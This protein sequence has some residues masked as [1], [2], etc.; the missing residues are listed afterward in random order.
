MSEESISHWVR[1]LREEGDEIAAQKL[2]DRYFDRLVLYARKRFGTARRRAFDEEDAALSAFH[3]LCR[4]AV[5]GRFER[6][7]DRNDLWQVLVTLAHRSVVD[8]IRRE[9]RAKRGGFAVRGES[10]FHALEDGGGGLDQQIDEE[11][12]PDLEVEIDEQYARLLD[13]LASD[14]E[15]DVARLRIQGYTNP[16]IAD[17]IGVSLRSVERKLANVRKAWDRQVR[18]D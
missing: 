1:R 10:V 11:I 4:G 8:R 7:D 9:G 15:R 16:E 14:V 2:W 5:E 17:R 3:G 6:L 18:V 13:T 12:T